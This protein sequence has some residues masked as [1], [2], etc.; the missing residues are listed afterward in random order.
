M[1]SSTRALTLAVVILLL[2]VG[3]GFTRP[4]TRSKPAAP[5]TEAAVQINGDTSNPVNQIAAKAIAD[6]EAFWKTEFPK[7]YGREY[8]P[9]KGGL[10][11]VVPSS[12][13]LPPCAS[14]KADIAGNAFYCPKSDVVAWDAEGLLP[15][16]RK[17]FGD[18][19]IPVVLAH[20]FGHA[21]QARAEFSGLTVTKEIQADCF[22]GAWAAHAI[23]D[24]TFTPSLNDQD[25]ALAGFLFLRDEPGTQKDDP[26]AHGSGFDRVSSYRTG[27]EEGTPRCKEYRDGDPVVTE[28]PFNSL[29]DVAS[30][31]NA[32]YED[33]INLVPVDLEDYWSKV[34]PLIADKPWQPLQAARP[35]DP[36]RPPA[37][38]GAPVTEYVL[39][40]CVPEDYVGFDAVKTMPAIYDEAGDFAVSTLIATQYGLAAL[41]RFGQG[42]SDKNT[43]LR[44]DCLAGAW[45]ANLL[46][47]TR[48]TAIFKL[49][50]GD[51]DKAVAALLIF[52]GSGDV[53]RQGQGAERVD[54]YRDGV[55]EGV[56]ECLSR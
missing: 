1:R 55:Y 21:I 50:P 20:E 15:S 7:L 23:N 3:C 41:D 46:L 42:S 18:F 47:A 34:F 43:S 22:A 48:E 24:K 8:T 11:A 37:C 13:K 12:G 51:L 45:A 14:S 49:S 52:R 16:L 25:R 4:T 40:Y 28:I 56:K 6:I 27:F 2:C 31:G 36:R 35:F 19:V 53:Q 44:A 33:I 17:R 32:P 10:Y 26:R 29:V 30:G 39:F 54:A 5:S 9:V 38:G